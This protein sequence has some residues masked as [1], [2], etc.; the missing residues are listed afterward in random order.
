MRARE[1]SE[2]KDEEH[3]VKTGRKS[4]KEGRPLAYCISALNQRPVR[5]LSLFSSFCLSTT[6]AVLSGH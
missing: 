1:E 6:R 2:K 3:A 5:L 4:G